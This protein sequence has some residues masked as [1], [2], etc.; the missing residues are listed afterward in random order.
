M[1]IIQGVND[2]ALPRLAVPSLVERLRVMPAVVVTG[3]RQTGKTTL[4]R[5]LTPGPRRFYS[6]D[7]WDVRDLARRSPDELLEGEGPV[8]ID[9]V[10]KEPRIMEAVKRAVDAGR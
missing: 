1:V 10:Q 2:N 8:T 3:A 5:K 4:V 7:D 6:L 9:E